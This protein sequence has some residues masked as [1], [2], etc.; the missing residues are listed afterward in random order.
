MNPLPPP[1]AGGVGGGVTHRTN[2]NS[3]SSKQ[4]AN[5]NPSDDI[6][7]RVLGTNLQVGA[8][9]AVLLLAAFSAIGALLAYLIR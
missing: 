8:L 4:M 5:H 1:L 3:E 9:R 2:Q 7:R 6:L